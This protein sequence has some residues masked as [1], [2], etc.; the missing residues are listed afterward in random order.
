MEKKLGLVEVQRLL[1]RES[2]GKVRQQFRHQLDAEGLHFLRL[3]EQTEDDL[4][5]MK[6][7]LPP[8]PEFRLP[9]HFGVPGVTPFPSAKPQPKKRLP[10]YSLATAALILLGLLLTPFLRNR[11]AE[12]APSLNPDLERGGAWHPEE[13]AREGVELGL[14]DVV[15]ENDARALSSMLAA[16]ADLHQVD[17]D[18]RNAVMLAAMEDLPEILTVLLAA[19]LSPN[20]VDREGRTALMLATLMGNERSV[21]L[22]LEA[23]ADLRIRDHQGVDAL[24]LARKYRFRR[25]EAL[26]LQHSRQPTREGR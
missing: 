7:W 26:L 14:L 12:P 10:P 16:G 17:E 2:S 6:R 19:G 23:G 21:S 15:L 18:G 24:A 3:L 4:S 25:C 11:S 13:V 1:C 8:I 5:E 9:D 22:L 20:Q